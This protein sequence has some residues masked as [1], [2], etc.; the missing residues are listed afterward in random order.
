MRQAV[1]IVFG[2]G[3][4]VVIR[5]HVVDIFF[6]PM[7]GMGRS[8]FGD[9]QILGRGRGASRGARIGQRSVLYLGKAVMGL[10]DCLG[11]R[12]FLDG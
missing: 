8:V 12:V 11:G 2:L 5:R 10:A 7:I 3:G 6:F 1:F 9:C 4:R